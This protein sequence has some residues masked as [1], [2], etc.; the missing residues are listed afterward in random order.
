VILE[1]GALKK[2]NSRPTD[3]N[4]EDHAIGN[5]QIFFFDPSTKC[6]KKPMSISLVF[7]PILPK[8]KFNAEK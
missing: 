1:E 4:F 8:K 7:V 2:K 5:T 3:P 6:A